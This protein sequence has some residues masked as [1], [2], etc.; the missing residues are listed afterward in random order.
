MIN[1]NHWFAG[2]SV[3]RL[4]LRDWKVLRIYWKPFSYQ[5]NSFSLAKNCKIA[6]KVITE[7]ERAVL[8]FIEGD[9]RQMLKARLQEVFDA[10]QL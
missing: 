1:G 9:V 5:I 7:K 4:R 2:D 8:F 3:T 10:L 6:S